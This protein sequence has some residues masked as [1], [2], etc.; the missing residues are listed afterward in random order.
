MNTI[1][2][3]LVGDSGVGKTVTRK[4]VCSADSYAVDIQVGT[5]TWLFAIWDSPGHADYD[6]NRLPPSSENLKKK[7][8]PE[9][10]HHCPDALCIVV[11]TQMEL[12][13]DL[14]VVEKMP[15]SAKTHQG[16]KSVF[17]QAIAAAVADMRSRERK[18]T[19][20]LLV[21]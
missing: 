3:V 7:W 1:K 16:V 17:D 15:C 19:R 20:R 4:R 12:R 14:R 18:K 21:L 10:F 2:L 13:S 8:F 9:V 5:E 6:H 11:T